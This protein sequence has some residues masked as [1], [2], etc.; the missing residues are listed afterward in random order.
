PKGWQRIIK[1]A[2]NCVEWGDAEAKALVGEEKAPRT[3][4]ILRKITSRELMRFKIGLDGVSYRRPKEGDSVIAI[5]SAEERDLLLRSS[6]FYRVQLESARKAGARIAV[7]C[8]GAAGFLAEV[9]NFLKS[10]QPDCGAVMVQTPKT[11]LLLDGVTRVGL[12]ML[13]NALST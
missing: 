7:I 9:E 11:D 4:E 6:G 8:L 3:S 13:L 5:I 12:K 1:R 10:W 2:V